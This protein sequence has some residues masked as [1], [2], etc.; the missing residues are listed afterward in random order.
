MPR[1]RKDGPIAIRFVRAICSGKFEPTKAGGE[2][3]LAANQDIVTGEDPYNERQIE[4]N[5]RKAVDY[6]KSWYTDG[7]GFDPR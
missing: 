7:S 3:L 1:F 5:W 6:L 4:D 2:K